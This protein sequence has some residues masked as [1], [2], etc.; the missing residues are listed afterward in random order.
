MGESP[1]LSPIQVLDVLTKVDGPVRKKAANGGH[2][3]FQL[4]TSYARDD[5]IGSPVAML[6][7]SDNEDDDPI[8]E[9]ITTGDDVDS[10]VTVDSVWG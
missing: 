5:F 10:P 9:F 1:P 4:D 7:A 6:F 2:W 8:E 3:L